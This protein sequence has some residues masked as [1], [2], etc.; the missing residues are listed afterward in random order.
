MSHRLFNFN[1]RLKSP[2]TNQAPKRGKAVNR[3][4]EEERKL[5]AQSVVGGKSYVVNLNTKQAIKLELAREHNTHHDESPCITLSCTIPVMGSSRPFLRS[6]R[7]RSLN[8][9]C[10]VIKK[11]S[12]DIVIPSTSSPPRR[13][14]I[15]FESILT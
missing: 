5:P 2:T 4:R 12:F 7:R 11:I 9:Q 14:D 8:H 10:G 13:E 1:T 6:R 3:E 15:I